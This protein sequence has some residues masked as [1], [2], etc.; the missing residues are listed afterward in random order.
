MLAGAVGGAVAIASMEAFSVNTEFPL[1]A[2]PFA[3]SIVTVFA[4]HPAPTSFTRLS[5]TGTGSWPPATQSA[6]L[7]HPRGQ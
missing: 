4:R 2:I 1:V 7:N 5:A 3:T 6:S